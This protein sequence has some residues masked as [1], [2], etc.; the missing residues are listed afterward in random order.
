MQ[1]A[2]KA[3]FDFLTKKEKFDLFGQAAFFFIGALVL[4]F[5]VQLLQRDRYGKAVCKNSPAIFFAFLFFAA[6]H[7]YI[8]HDI[9]VPDS[10]R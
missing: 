3:S 8:R 1:R 4:C 10:S 6:M 5:E 2:G 9:H 7:L